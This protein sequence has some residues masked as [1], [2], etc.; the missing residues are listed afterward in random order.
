[1]A[2]SGSALD[3]A[4]IAQTEGKHANARANGENEEEISTVVCCLSRKRNDKKPSP[5][6]LFGYCSVPYRAVTFQ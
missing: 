1:M 6:A 2:I 5:V 3:S 4:L